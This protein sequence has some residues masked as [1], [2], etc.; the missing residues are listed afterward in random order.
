MKSYLNRIGNLML[1]ADSHNVSVGNNP[2]TDKLQS[3]EKS[4]MAQHREIKEFA[5]GKIWDTDSINDRH[6]KLVEFILE[7]W[8]L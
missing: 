8:S 6:K 5:N 4:P 1:I 3:Y 7:T 2:F